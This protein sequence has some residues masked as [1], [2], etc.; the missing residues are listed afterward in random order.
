[1]PPAEHKT[2]RDLSRSTSLSVLHGSRMQPQKTDCMHLYGNCLVVMEMKLSVAE[3][4][5]SS[6][7]N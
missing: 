5:S 4:I 6:I 1:M 2:I 7:N 3:N